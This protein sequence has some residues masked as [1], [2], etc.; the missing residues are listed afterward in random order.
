MKP[1]YLI[2][3]IAAAASVSAQATDSINLGSYTVAGTYALDIL[4]GT[5]G[6]ISG[7]EASAVAYAR[8]RGTLFFVGDEGTGVIEISRTGQTL[9]NMTFDWSNTGSTKHDTEGLTYLGGGVLVVG[10][11][12]LQDAYRFT[13]ATGGSA[14]LA[15]NSVSI[16]NTNVG[17]NGMEGISFDPRN[18]S[19]VTVKQGNPSD[20]VT[21]PEGIYAGTLTFS[22]GLAGTTGTSTMTQLFDP[23]LMGLATLSDVQTL[24]PVDALAGSAAADNLLVL[25]LGSKKLIEVNRLG[26]IMS[27]YDLSGILPGNAIEGVTI[28][29]KGTIYLVAE[30]LQDEYAVGITNPRSQLIV[31]SA[32]VPEP[33]TYAMMLAGLGLLGVAARHKREPR[34]TA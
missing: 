22:A 32:P 14:S 11:E 18:G 16:S 25:S 27:S 13:Y 3:A 4:N 23:A 17:N 7:L 28:D 8:D 1:R 6:G 29:E 2:A 12:R 34:G 19:F 33:E 30:Q 9:G 10:E 5:S 26:Q 31:L 20:P 15:A 24:S 21:Y